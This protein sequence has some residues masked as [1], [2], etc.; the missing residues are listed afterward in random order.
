MESNAS[1]PINNPET[2][3][4]SVTPPVNNQRS[5]FPIILGVLALLLVV[6]GGAY[7]LGT[8]NNR[9]APQ[10][11][12]I[13][14]QPTINPKNNPTDWPVT[15][16]STQSDEQADWKTFTSKICN[17][18]LKTPLTWS[19]NDTKGTDTV[20]YDFTCTSLSAPD[21]RAT[22]MD[23]VE[24]LWMG[25]HRTPIGSTFNSFDTIIINTL[26][27]YITATETIQQPKVPAKN[28]QNKTY[29]K[30][31]GKY[32]EYEAFENTSN[33]IFVQGSYIYTV[34]WDADYQGNYKNDIDGIISS[35]A[36]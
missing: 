9:S 35:L 28:V 1:Q 25:I 13:Y 11:Q 23:S 20:G 3:A 24:G 8:Q 18:N 19:I 33:F 14:A 36:F 22:G 5:N 4:Q 21:F 15:T 32:F 10:T 7:Y 2:P 12:N 29:G 6:G 31:S 16:Q 27:D 34:K 30:L 26:E 17:F